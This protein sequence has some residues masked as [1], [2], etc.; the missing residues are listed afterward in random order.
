MKI[1]LQEAVQIL[2][3]KTEW[4]G[5]WDELTEPQ[6]Q[7]LQSAIDEAID[8]NWDHF[9]SSQLQLNLKELKNI[10]DS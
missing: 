10:A 7:S 3:Q 6:K 2:S 4:D 5:V 9:R 8:L 1:T